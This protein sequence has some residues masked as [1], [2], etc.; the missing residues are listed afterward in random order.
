MPNSI[1]LITDNS[2]GTTSVN[3]SIGIFKLNQYYKPSCNQS[4][5]T[6]DYVATFLASNICT[7]MYN[8]Y[9]TH[10]HSRLQNNNISLWKDSKCISG[11][12]LILNIT[13]EC[14]KNPLYD[15]YH[16][17]LIKQSQTQTIL[18]NNIKDNLY[19]INII[20]P[21]EAVPYN[22][23]TLTID[24]KIF[25]FNLENWGKYGTLGTIFNSK[26]NTNTNIVIPGTEVSFNYLNSVYCN[27]R[28]DLSYCKYFKNNSTNQNVVMPLDFILHTASEIFEGA[29]TVQF[30]NFD[31]HLNQNNYF[32]PNIDLSSSVILNRINFK[33]TVFS[34]EKQCEGP[35]LNVYTMNSEPT[36]SYTIPM[37]SVFRTFDHIYFLKT[38]S[39]AGLGTVD[40]QIV[41]SQA[42]G[43]KSYNDNHNNPWKN[44]AIEYMSLE[45]GFN[46]NNR[47]H[48]PIY[49]NTGDTQQ[50]MIFACNGVGS[51]FFSAHGYHKSIFSDPI[52]IPNILSITQS[53]KPPERN[54]QAYSNIILTNKYL[55]LPWG[56][57]FVPALNNPYNINITNKKT[58]KDIIE[59]NNIC[60]D[61]SFTAIYD[62]FTTFNGSDEILQGFL[63]T[64]YYLDTSYG[65]MSIKDISSYFDPNY[66]FKNEFINKGLYKWTPQG[67]W[68][69]VFSQE[70]QSGGPYLMD[71]NSYIL[72]PQLNMPIDNNLSLIHI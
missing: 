11:K 39:N 25:E 30:K 68:P 67:H 18:I 72:I 55:K 27:N 43:E 58:S 29:Y 1:Y 34:N 40:P 16:Y 3:Y 44:Y 61:V 47:D 33:T 12:P 51:S 14:T 57:D 56:W 53:N 49:N 5:S 63:P 19:G 54:A 41:H 10:T 22:N 42:T 66:V 46:Y 59:L 8:E 2:Q 21:P 48:K 20:I 32:I 28:F 24:S 36:I 70:I 26:F 64:F 9:A 4:P 17:T 65:M 7:K 15:D 6:P 69:I 37:Q 45:G 31:I 23:F 35:L 50:L 38:N 62:I 71:D 60:P 13:D 52:S